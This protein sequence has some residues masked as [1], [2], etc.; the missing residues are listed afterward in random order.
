MTDLNCL[1]LTQ[2]SLV[3]APYLSL[4]ALLRRF[5]IKLRLLGFSP[6]ES[7]PVGFRL[8]GSFLAPTLPLSLSLTST[9]GIIEGWFSDA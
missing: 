3:F 4:S 5:S 8:L 1:L 6:P 2:S 9:H 7:I